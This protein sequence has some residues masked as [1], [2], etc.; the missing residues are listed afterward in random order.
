MI[1]LFASL[2]SLFLV[3]AGGG[4]E[5]LARYPWWAFDLNFWSG[6]IFL[7]LVAIVATMGSKPIWEGTAARQK[8]IEEQIKMAE[9]A[10]AEIKDLRQRHREERARAQ[11]RAEEM[12]A[13]A[14]R[15]GERLRSEIVGRAETEAK[16]ITTRVT[17]DLGLLK[18][19]VNSELWETTATLSAGMAEKLIRGGA[20]RDDHLRLVDEAIAA[21]DGAEV[22]A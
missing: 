5:G 13:E 12:V 20:S 1:H 18:A 11:L 22:R 9:F 17:R 21:L 6:I 10:A 4:G 16:A 3:A 14:R 2:D 8:G 15:D 7:A 19:K